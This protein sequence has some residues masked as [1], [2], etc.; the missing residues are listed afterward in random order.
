MDWGFILECAIKSV[1]AVIIGGVIGSERARH[2]RAAGMRTHI[3]VSVGSCV[4][5]LTSQV[6]FSKY[7]P[8]GIT[9]DPARLSAQV[10]SGVGFLGAGTIMREGLTVKGLTTAASLWTVACLGIAA[11]GGFYDVALLGMVFVSGILQVGFSGVSELKGVLLGVG[12][13]ALKKKKGLGLYM[14]RIHTKKDTIL[15][16]TNV[17]ILRA[18]IVSLI[19]CGAVK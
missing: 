8:F 2:G 18:A 10:I 19:T 5:M 13:A 4:V 17:N 11:G 15:E 1:L 16:E 6:I 9:A 7:L 12:A 3:L 14:N